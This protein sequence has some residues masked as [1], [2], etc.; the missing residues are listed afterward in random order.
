MY[1]RQ[2][3]G[4][5]LFAD[6]GVEWFLIGRLDAVKLLLLLQDLSVCDELNGK[7]SDG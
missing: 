7:G 3:E 4:Y 6:F 2:V 5:N 1:K